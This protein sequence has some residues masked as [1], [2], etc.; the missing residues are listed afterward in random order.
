VHGEA[1]RSSVVGKS[2]EQLRLPSDVV[3]CA[4]LRGDKALSA[5]HDLVIENQD[6]IVLFVCDK[7]HIKTVE[8]LFQVDPEY[9]T[10]YGGQS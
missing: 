6:H 7:K 2:I 8:K 9:I 10:E 5:T 3:V 1:G 4:V